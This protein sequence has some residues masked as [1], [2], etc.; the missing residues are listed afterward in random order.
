[1]SS[2]ASLG[3]KTAKKCVAPILSLGAASAGS[4]ANAQ[5]MIDVFTGKLA[6]DIR[7][8]YLSTLS[9][10]EPAVKQANEQKCGLN[11]ANYRLMKY[12]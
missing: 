9:D 6:A 4:D 10:S 7:Q 1:M 5:D 2:G 3:P 8:D 11:A 12:W